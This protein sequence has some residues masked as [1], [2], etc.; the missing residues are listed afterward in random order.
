MVAGMIATTRGSIL[1]GE[2]IKDAL[3]DEIE[4]N[5]AVVEGYEDL[6]LGLTEKSRSV[7]D[8]AS[9]TWRTIRYFVGRL[10]ANVKL[11]DGD[12]IKDNRTGLI[13][14]IDE[15]EPTRRSISGRSSLSLDLRR[16]GE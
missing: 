5:D 15:G 16:S 2:T 10:P 4:D 9:G 14:I 3:G 12:R 7:Q 1:R 6:P 13:Y 8:P 11:E